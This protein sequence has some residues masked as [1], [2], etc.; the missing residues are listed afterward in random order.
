MLF[1]YYSGWEVVPV[2]LAIPL[3]HLWVLP[4]PC[5]QWGFRWKEGRSSTLL[6]HG[7]FALSARTCLQMQA[8]EGLTGNVP[9]QNIVFENLHAGG[10]V[11]PPVTACQ[12]AFSY[13]P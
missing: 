11:Q 12:K 10:Q 1:Y 4:A 7:S 13:L 9:L 2:C 8:E 6:L 5:L 3:G